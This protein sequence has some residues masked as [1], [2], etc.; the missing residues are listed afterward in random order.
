MSI[1]FFIGFGCA[2][3]AWTF[4]CILCEPG[5]IFGKLPVMLEKA[6]K[7]SI[8]FQ[9]LTCEKCLSGQLALWMYPAHQFHQYDVFNH[10]F[11]TCFAILCA[12][13]VT[14]LANKLER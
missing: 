2:V 10:L 4:V 14:L 11:V 7:K 6:G 9:V 3:M 8:V 5:E 12:Y 13:F 1:A